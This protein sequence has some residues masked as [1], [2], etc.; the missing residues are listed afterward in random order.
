AKR[1]WFLSMMER[2]A[3][4]ETEQL[5]TRWGKSCVFSESTGLSFLKHTRRPTLSGL[6]EARFR[7]AKSSKVASSIPE[8]F[9]I[10]THT[11]RKRT[12]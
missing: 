2:G 10:N 6:L 9:L 4:P 1:A 12:D 3:K 5:L 7:E 8:Y 11:K